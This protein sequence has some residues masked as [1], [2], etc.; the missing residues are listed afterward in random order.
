LRRLIVNADDFGFTRDVNEG[1]ALAFRQGILR[2]T[3]LM[4]NGAAFEH[5]VET[6]QAH[7]GLDV[8]CHLTLVGGQSVADPGRLLPGSV[9]RLLLASRGAWPRSAIEEECCA[10]MEKILAAGI[11]VSHVDAHKHTHLFPA[12][13]DSVTRAAQRYGVTWVRRPFDVPLT[14]AAARSRWRRRLT[15]R[16]LAGLAARFDRKLAAA[17]LRTTDAFAGFQLT[18]LYRAEQLA[19]LIRALPEGVSEFMC[20]PGLCGDEL[21]AA[22]TRLKQSREEE[23]AALTSGLVLRAVEEARVEIMSF[24]ELAG[25]PMP[26][27]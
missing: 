17:G 9:A 2:S 10:Q 12:V 27:R 8:G 23:L 25:A 15:S 7:P 11:S 18:G 6:A 5:A 21:R 24:R 1:I 26:P 4:A 14:A 19:A 22:R 13:L 3:T 16:L 20:H